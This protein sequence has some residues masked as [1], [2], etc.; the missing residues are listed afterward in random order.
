MGPHRQ[1]QL[2]D[3]WRHLLWS[4]FIHSMICKQKGET[5]TDA[6]AFENLGV[7]KD[8]NILAFKEFTRGQDAED[9]QNDH[10]EYAAFVKKLFSKSHGPTALQQLPDWANFLNSVLTTKPDDQLLHSSVFFGDEEMASLYIDLHRLVRHE[11]K[12]RGLGA[13][14]TKILQEMEKAYTDAMVVTECRKNPLLAHL[15]GQHGSAKAKNAPPGSALVDV[16]RIAVSH[17][18]EK[19]LLTKVQTSSPTVDPKLLQT[20]DRKEVVRSLKYLFPDYPQAALN[21]FWDQRVWAKLDMDRRHPVPSIYS[22]WS[23]DI[24]ETRNQE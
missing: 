10:T 3:R 1:L 2:N 13:E 11:F 5:I 20:Y 18:I 7:I 14:G 8:L 22:L 17:A 9:T 24:E 15:L 6:F 21:S 23:P 12:N 16:H 4:G 19:E